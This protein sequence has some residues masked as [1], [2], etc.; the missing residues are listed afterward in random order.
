ME[1]KDLS[2]ELQQAVEV[3]GKG[4]THIKVELEANLNRNVDERGEEPCDEC[5]DGTVECDEC[6]G[7]TVVDQGE[8]EVECERCSGDGFETCHV[9][10]GD[11][12]IYVENNS[13]DEYCEEFIC[14]YVGHEAWDKLNFQK[15]YYDG[16]VDSEFTFTLPIEHVGYIPKFIDAFRAL[17]DDIGHGLETAGAG[18]HIAVLTRSDYCSGHDCGWGGCKYCE[19]PPALVPNKIRNFRNQVQKLLPALYFVASADHHSRGLEYRY[20][21]I[22]SDEKYSA[23]YTKDDT[24]LE[25]RLFET[26]YERPQTVFDYIE[27]IASTLKYYNDARLKVKSTGQRFDFGA[28]GRSVG[29]FYDTPEKLRILNAQITHV[30]PKGKTYHQLKKERNF[31]HTVASLRKRHQKRMA[32][33]RQDYRQY[34]RHQQLNSSDTVTFEDYVA[35]HLSNGS[36]ITI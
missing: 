27:V 10:D 21:R 2:A 35:S 24:C 15:F 5:D 6:Y 34:V 31:T 23:I 36:S 29:R 22:S 7:T 17:G 19:S 11:G 1:L 32:T 20:P 18:M 16:S 14:E 12:Y 8:F 28:R 4:F 3:I 26:C 25:Y 30:K 33:F 9:C 13:D